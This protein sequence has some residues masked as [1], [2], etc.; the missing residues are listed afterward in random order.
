MRHLLTSILI[1]LAATVAS[2]GVVT[3][4]TL[5]GPNSTLFTTVTEDGITVNS[6][7]GT[8]NQA[9]FVGNPVPALYTYSTSASLEVLTGGT[10][11]FTS[12]DFGTGG[13]LGP[14]Y[15]VIGY[16]ASVEVLNFS[17]AAVDDIFHTISNS[18]PGVV[19]DRLVIAT[20][21]Q[22]TSANVDNIVV[23]SAEIPEPATFALVALGLFIL[24]KRR[25]N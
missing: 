25:R 8:W 22:S 11:T 6:L 24:V 14:A 2:A 10:F 21:L 16:L 18:N 7:S 15:Q 19:L 20:T 4:D 3:F 23:D 1:I 17:G 9:F 12:V 5:P 13:S